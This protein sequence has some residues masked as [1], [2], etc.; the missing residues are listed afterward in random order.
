MRD[1]DLLE[2]IQESPWIA[3]L[4]A[5]FDFDVARVVNGPVEPVHLANGE[6]LE[7]IAGDASGGA[8][9]LAGTVGETRPV[10]YVG[11][12][13]EG[14][15]IA[16]GL[17][18]ALALVVGLPSLHDA[19]AIPAAED[20]GAP[21]RAWLAQADDEIREDWPDLDADR[22]RLRDAL[23]LPAADGLLASLQASAANDHF[24]P[25]NNDGNKYDSMLG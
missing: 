24:R 15:L 13:G 1:V 18:D 17:R 2:L 8:F 16:T 25:V 21:L 5:E 4:L 23:D 19:T 3:D 14:G 7:M 22:T 6:S 12:E 11:S 9:M 10:V 20:G